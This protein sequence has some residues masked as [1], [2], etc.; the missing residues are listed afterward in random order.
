RFVRDSERLTSSWPPAPGAAFL[1]ESAAALQDRQG[2][3]VVGLAERLRDRLIERGAALEEKAP[4]PGFEL[5][6]LLASSALVKGTGAEFPFTVLTAI[7]GIAPTFDKRA[8][9][10]QESGEL[11]LSCALLHT[12]DVFAMFSEGWFTAGGREWM[13][14]HRDTSASQAVVMATDRLN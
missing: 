11:Q 12:R 5:S 3:E 8:R 10:W 14:S 1:L 2:Q 4:Q 7:D 13:R 6:W 9:R